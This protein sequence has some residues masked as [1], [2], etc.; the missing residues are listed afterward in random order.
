MESFLPLFHELLELQLGVKVQVIR[1]LAPFL[2]TNISTEH[3]L[4][5][6]VIFLVCLRI[7]LM[8]IYVIDQLLMMGEIVLFCTVIV[9]LF[10]LF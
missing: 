5:G 1:N 7:L 3:I 8:R 4:I 2:L 9:G 10:L 6:L